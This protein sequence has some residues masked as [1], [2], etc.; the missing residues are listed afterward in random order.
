MT[1]QHTPTTERVKDSY[2]RSRVWEVHDGGK[3]YDSEFDRWLAQVEAAAEQRG[4]ERGWDHAIEHVSQLE[5]DVGF[6]EHY[7]PHNPYRADQ[8]E[9]DDV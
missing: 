3:T 2:R 5:A 6:M 9:G 4:A 7:K 1:E 8:M